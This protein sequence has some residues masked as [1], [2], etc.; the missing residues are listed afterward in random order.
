MTFDFWT[1]LIAGQPEVSLLIWVCV[2]MLV[3]YI[4]RQPA[5][6]IILTLVRSIRNAL[7]LMA[8]SVM[9]AEKQLRLKE[10]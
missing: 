9:L 10:S 8:Q 4:A 6:Q 5:H 2:L 3:M 7:R 1:N